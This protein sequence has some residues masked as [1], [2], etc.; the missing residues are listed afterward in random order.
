MAA[1]PSRMIPIG[2]VMPTFSLPNLD[3][4][5]WSPSNDSEGT[6]VVFMCNHCPY[7]IHVADTLQNLYEVCLSNNIDMIGIN[8]NNFEAYPDDSPENMIR[9]S[10]LYNWDF[11]YLLDREQSVASSFGATCTP[12]T[13]LFDKGNKLFYRGQCDDSRPAKGVSTGFDLISAISTLIE[14][15]PPPCNQKP[16]IG[17]N[18]KWK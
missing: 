12:D 1:T 4:T 7:V 3:G 6:L 8:S 10:D 11:P 13:F 2:T 18:I 5:Q 15:D 16:S 14:N 17:C 9:T